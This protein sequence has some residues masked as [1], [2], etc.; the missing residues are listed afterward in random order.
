MTTQPQFPM[1]F[2]KCPVCGGTDTITKAFK[3]VLV[4]KGLFREEI[5]VAMAQSV[6][7]FADPSAIL[8]GVRAPALIT[9]YDVCGSC[10]CYYC[11]RVDLGEVELQAPGSMNQP[12]FQG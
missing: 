5:P 3:R 10:G 7:P 2:D 9:K 4:E 12:K 1:T 11:V 6:T 8:F